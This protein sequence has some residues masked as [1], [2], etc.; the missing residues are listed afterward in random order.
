ME[1]DDW[2]KAALADAER[3]GLADLQPMLDTLVRAT[4]ALR[5]ADWND[6]P[7]GRTNSPAASGPERSPS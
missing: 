3:R 5:R 7:T 6:D 1:L 2:L 4:R